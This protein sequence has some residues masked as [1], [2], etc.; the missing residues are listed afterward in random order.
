MST[1]IEY[2]FDNLTGRI[3]TPGPGLP[4]DEGPGKNG[5]IAPRTRKAKGEPAGYLG[6]L[7][8]MAKTSGGPAL[9][10]SLGVVGI[11]FL[12]YFAALGTAAVLK[13]LG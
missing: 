3:N 2:Q 12:I 5:G 8:G 13:A 4:A 1:N 7:K 11:P 9:L 6:T 10:V